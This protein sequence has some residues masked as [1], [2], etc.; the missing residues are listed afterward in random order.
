[1]HP[2]LRFH[3]MKL[4]FY[5]EDAT[6]GEVVECMI[7]DREETLVEFENDNFVACLPNYEDW[8]FVRIKL[9]ERSTAFFLK[10]VQKIDPLS[11]LL[12]LRSFFEMVK[13]AEMK[14]TDFVDVLVQ[15]FLNKRTLD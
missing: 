6:V 9:D 2:T 13:D 3:K 4:A 1:M 8:S 14:G 10:N 15:Q 5:K 12:V 7:Q 11:Q